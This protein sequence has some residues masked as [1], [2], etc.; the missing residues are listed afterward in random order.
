VFKEGPSF[1]DITQGSV[2]DCYFLAALACVAEFPELIKARF[3]TKKINKAG[4]YAVS[5]FI[6]GKE[7]V[8]MVDDHFMVDQWNRPQYAKFSHNKMW[9]AILEKVWQKM[10]GSVWRTHFGYNNDA[11][12]PFLGNAVYTMIHA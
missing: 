12:M 5:L 4:I 7:K 11:I 10:L 8:V 3:I 2:G 9:V 1:D 6:N